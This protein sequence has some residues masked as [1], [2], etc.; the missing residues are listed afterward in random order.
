MRGEERLSRNPFSMSLLPRWF[1]LA[2][3]VLGCGGVASAQS[4]ALSASSSTYSSGGGS[5]TF[6]AT[7]TYSGSVSALGLSVN[8]PSGWTYGSASGTVPPIAPSA[9][10]SGGFDF[11][12]TSIPASPVSFSF[13]V[14]YPA[15]MTGAQTFS[16]SAI[17]RPTGGT[18]QTVNISSITLTARTPAITS[19]TSVNATTNSEFSY[20]VTASDSPTSFSATGLPSWL[21]LN[22]TSG[23]I[24]GT[25]TSAGSFSFSV[26]ATN[27][28]GAGSPTTVTVTVSDPTPP[29][30]GGGGPTP[31]PVPTILTHPSSQTVNQGS[32]ATFSVTAT[33]ATGYQWR[34]DGTSISGATAS[35]YTVS[36]AQPSSAG[37][38]SVVVSNTSGSVTSN[39]ASLTV[40]PTNVIV[41]PAITGQP[42]SVVVGVGSRATF[43]VSATGGSLAYQWRR[44]GTGISGATA[45]SYTVAFAATETAGDYSVTVTNTAGAVTS[46]AATLS[47][48]SVEYFGTFANNGGTFALFIR[49]DRT[50]VFLAYARSS[51]TA[52]VTKDVVLD[53]NGRFSVTTTAPAEWLEDGGRTRAA[54]ATEFV[55][56]GAIGS[57]GSISG[58]VSGLGLTM[59]APAP[60]LS[61]NT[62]GSAG[63]Y[64]SGAVGSSATSYTIIGPAGDVY[65]ATVSSTGADAGKGT[66]D[67]AGN[68]SLTT[69][70]N[71]AVTGRIDSSSGIAITATP[72]GSNK[73]VTY[74]GGNT[75]T[76]TVERLINLST[77]ATAG[78]GDATLV[79]GFS[80]NGTAP[81]RLLIR[82]VGPGLTQFGVGGVIATPQVKLYS[83]Q[84][85]IAQNAGWSTS[86]DATAIAAAA[87]QSNAFPLTTGSKDS[88]LLLY[89]SPGA[90][91]AQV[92]ST[93]G[94]T[95]I[96]LV[97]VY[98][99]P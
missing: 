19:S 50:G 58:S 63:F 8:A 4:A 97:E 5:I 68:L 79:V 67:S 43:S 48:R 94:S 40:T 13:T 32:N 96:A 16:A 49:P 82:G 36:N 83:G 75:D 29:G 86:A 23:V 10:D 51:K 56:D 20:A 93:D 95:G 55:I 27:G 71:A 77:R 47:V 84:T 46:N 81:K 60:T 12:Y 6:T 52:L 57:D 76:R 78:A 65:V 72:A 64:Q 99:V 24:S 53:L 54:A 33:G 15:G 18:L 1:F 41:A 80:V 3:A 21:S 90:Y 34:K 91:T 70:S 98:E 39:G 42:A 87:A 73:P 45:A 31:D 2:F 69:E 85:V 37:T 61:G 59:S 28:A 92:S 66:I 88:A 22:A 17:F 26:R 74:A 14:N 38:Y 7:L 62:S 25:P 89:L 30:G 44:N 35:S 11:T 9:G